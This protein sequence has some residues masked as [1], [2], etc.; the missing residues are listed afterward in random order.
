MLKSTQLCSIV[1][2][3]QETYTTAGRPDGSVSSLQKG[4][5]PAFYHLIVFTTPDRHIHKENK[6]DFN[7]GRSDASL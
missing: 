1:I 3:G 7:Y 6:I 5:D 2:W 4:Q